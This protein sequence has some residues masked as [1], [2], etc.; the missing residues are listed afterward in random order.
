MM[1]ATELSIALRPDLHYM[2]QLSLTVV[3]RGD[4]E[5]T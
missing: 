5:L 4:G 1:Q 2:L 3:E